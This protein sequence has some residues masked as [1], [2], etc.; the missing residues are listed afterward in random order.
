MVALKKLVY[1]FAFLSIYNASAKIFGPVQEVK[2]PL[3]IAD[4]GGVLV[5]QNQLK[6]IPAYVG[7]LMESNNKWDLL[8]VSSWCFYH[9]S[10]LRT[11][12]LQG[13]EDNVIDWI[14]T[15]HPA[16]NEY[17]KSEVK[18]A[19][20]I[21][22]VMCKG[23]SNQKTQ[24]IISDLMKKGYPVALGSNKGKQ[25]IERFINDGI[26]LDL[27]Y[28]LIFTC[29]AHDQAAAGIYYKKPSLDYFE[30]LKKDLFKAGYENNTFIFIDNDLAN[31]E[32]ACKAG[33]VGIYYTTPEKL[34]SDL[35]DL[36]IK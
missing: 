25:T 12:N 28:A 35:A 17:T 23:T 31:V 1:L 6:N 5:D 29:D 19:D 16:V 22:E 8:K 24:K 10:E 15:N 21:K 20:R 14:A 36:A 3:I 34:A 11:M 7:I 18:I 9:F 33:M 26:L 30:N 27:N 32:A 4:V 13:P 2:N